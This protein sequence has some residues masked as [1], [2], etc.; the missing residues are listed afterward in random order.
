MFFS[1]FYAIIDKLCVFKR[2]IICYNGKNKQKRERCVMY[3]ILVVDDEAINIKLVSFALKDEYEVV[4]AGSGKECLEK[5]EKEKID[6]V[7][8]DILMPEMDG[9]ETLDAIRAN[10]DYD[11]IPAI[12]LTGA[13]EI[14]GDN[15]FIRKPIV[16][17]FLKERLEEVLG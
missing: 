3:R 14:K 12:Y 8:L 10:H 4:G 13:D 16:P 17:Q 6:A 1:I 15:P 2:K 5:L 11:E 7:L 9:Y